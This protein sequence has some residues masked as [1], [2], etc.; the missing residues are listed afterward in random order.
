MASAADEAKIDI[1]EE[2]DIDDVA[3][4]TNAS[5]K[6]KSQGGEMPDEVFSVHAVAI[7]KA[8]Q[9]LQDVIKEGADDKEDA[10]ATEKLLETIVDSADKCARVNAPLLNSAKAVLQTVKDKESR[11]EAHIAV[12]TVKD[13][14]I[15]ALIAPWRPRA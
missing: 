8:A 14:A 3:A 4:V 5:Y 9:A 6:T 2:R 10:E 11:V 12:Q 13:Q 1:D 7:R 15:A